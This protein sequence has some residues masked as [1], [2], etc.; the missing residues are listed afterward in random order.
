MT[1]P[2]VRTALSATLAPTEKSFSSTHIREQT[3]EKVKQFHKE[4]NNTFSCRTRRG[5][6]LL[7]PMAIVALLGVIVIFGTPVSAGGR[8]AAGRAQKAA[9]AKARHFYLLGAQH[10]ATGD[11]A[12]AADLFRRAYESDSTYADGALEFGLRRWG[13]PSDTMKT[14]SESGES[15][16]IARKFLAQY[17]GDLF[18]NLLYSSMMEQAGDMD[19][20]ITVLET[21][22]RH[23]P[24]NTSVLQSLVSAYLDNRRFED[25]LDAYAQYERIEGSDFETLVR[26]VGMLVAIGDTARAY[27]E[28]RSKIREY[29]VDPQYRMFLAQLYNFDA[30]PDS[31]L[32]YMV[33]AEKLYESGFGGPVKIQMADYYRQQGDSVNYDA[34]VYEALLTEDLDFDAKREL[35]TYYLGDMVRMKNDQS[36][37]DRLFEVLRNQYPHEPAML[38]LSARYYAAKGDF[39]SALEDIDYALDQNHTDLDLWE[40]AML[41]CLMEDDYDRARGYMARAKELLPEVPM[42]LYSLAAS[43]CMMDGKP[44]DALG[45]LRESLATYFPGQDLEKPLD[46]KA[47][48]DYL[49]TRNFQDLTSLYSTAGDAYYAIEDR[50]H[51]YV[52]YDNSLFLDDSNPLTLNNYAYYLVKTDDDPDPETLAKADE[53]SE[54]AVA[55]APD[56]PTYLD[57]RAWVLYRL[58]QYEAARDV[59][60]RALELAADRLTEPEAAEYFNHYGDILEKLGEA[61]QAREQWRKA[62]ELNPDDKE[63]QKKLK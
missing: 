2:P 40:Q 48:R 26:K 13:V 30:K 32:K 22:D 12:E 38:G 49:T 19:E 50:E 39:K 8:N 23:N 58:G 1:A 53:M 43:A 27:E 14:P 34:K 20:A 16:R 52:N 47:L 33:E 36:R 15:K 4:K 29:P 57:T 42:R 46:Q 25:A 35:L 7:W 44:D 60:M 5:A 59:M 54:R 24:G 3:H 28:S 62:L 17:P 37:G 45:Y 41:F 63:L 10:M 55:I 21:L 56:N 31:A 11:N 61:P 9:R 6:G 51:A 18:P